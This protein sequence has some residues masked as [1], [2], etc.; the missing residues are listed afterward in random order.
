MKERCKLCEGLD[1]ISACVYH[2]M[3]GED[4]CERADR[5]RL[6]EQ[7]QDLKIPVWESEGGK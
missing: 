2:D 4:Y 1:L 7:D 5:G 3:H 6:E